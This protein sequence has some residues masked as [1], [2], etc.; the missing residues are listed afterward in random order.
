M[1]SK[2][3]SLAVSF[4]YFALPAGAVERPHGADL[5]A[6][7]ETHAKAHGVPITLLRRVI[8]RESGYNPRLMHSGNIG[9]MQ[10]RY[11]T[12]RSMGYKGAPR[13]LLDPEVNLTYATPYLANAYKVSS[14][15][16][17]RAVTLYSSGFYYAAK[18]QGLL[19]GMRDA[20]SASLA[21]PKTQALAPEPETPNPVVGL[22]QSL[23]D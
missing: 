8:A 15:S 7:I 18:R 6:M 1:I 10:I 9:L 19:S 14:G 2:R 13:G 22:L 16:E 4:V 11:A 17:D 23:L 21:S 5:D 12:A 3:I 20:S